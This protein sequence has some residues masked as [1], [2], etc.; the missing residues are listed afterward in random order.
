MG[1]NNSVYIDRCL[2]C[3]KVVDDY[4][5]SWC[6]NGQECSCRG[7]PTNPCVC[8]DKCEDAVYNYI[9]LEYE[10]RRI[11]AGIEKADEI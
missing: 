8:S 11:K 7:Q 5:P 3:G 6:C 1:K 9:G 4:E 10:E 2:I